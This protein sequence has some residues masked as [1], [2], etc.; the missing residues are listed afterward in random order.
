MRIGALSLMLG[1]ACAVAPG[2]ARGPR[3]PSA[4]GAAPASPLAI[5]LEGLGDHH[6]R[7][8]TSSSEAQAF[9]DQGLVLLYAANADE[10]V[11]SFREAAR[12]D[13]TAAMPWWGV[14]I[15]RGPHV[16][17]QVPDADAAAEERAAV[18]E[19]QTRAGAGTPVEQALVRALATRTLR[20][21]HDQFPD[22]PDVAALYAEERL[23]Q[24]APDEARAIVDALLARAPRH[25]GANHL[26]GHL[27]VASCGSVE[28][29]CVLSTADRLRTLAPGAGHLVHMGA[30]LYARLG[31]WSAACDAG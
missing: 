28:Q 30:R 24:D 13:P 10:A 12:L 3:P 26:H 18:V 31:R 4:H 5:A 6:R 15:A 17:A 8:S 19:A 23:L 14:A 2:C 22:D 20:E 7:I 25:P 29:E 1:V 27:V 9:F 16:D 21:V 11:R